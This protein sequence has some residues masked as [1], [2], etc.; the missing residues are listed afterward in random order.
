MTHAAQ[1]F[2]YTLFNGF[3]L[4]FCNFFFLEKHT[5]ANKVTYRIHRHVTSNQELHRFLLN[6]YIC[7]HIYLSNI[8]NQTNIYLVLLFTK[9]SFIAKGYNFIKQYYF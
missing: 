7:I 8:T 9:Y 6:I 2:G 5:G 1:Q 3:V 4:F